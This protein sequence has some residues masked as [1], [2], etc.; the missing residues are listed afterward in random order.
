MSLTT[1][2]QFCTSYWFR[3][4]L[5]NYL[6]YQQATRGQFHTTWATTFP[7]RPATAGRVPAMNAGCGL[8]A[9]GHWDGPVICNEAGGWSVCR[10]TW[11]KVPCEHA[12]AP[13]LGPSPPGSEGP[14]PIL[15]SSSSSAAVEAS[16]CLVWGSAS[17]LLWNWAGLTRCFTHVSERCQ[18]KWKRTYIASAL[19]LWVL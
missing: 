5:E 10:A 7:G 6:L 15:V 3:I 11:R 19:I 18:P 17:D 12:K 9:R 14:T 4:S 1:G 13:C 8:S 2:N 16:A